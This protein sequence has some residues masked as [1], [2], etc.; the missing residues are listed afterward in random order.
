MIS[1]LD[2]KASLAAFLIALAA[3]GGAWGSQLFGGL[4]PCELCLEQ[5][6][7]YYLGVPVLAL[8]LLAWNRL[9]LPAWYLLMAVAIGCFALGAYMAGYHAGVEYGFWPGPTT[10]TGTGGPMSFDDLRK[11]DEARVVPC[12]KVQF[13]L[14]GVSLA[15]FNLLAQLAVVGLLLVAVW[16]QV[17]RQ[18]RAVAA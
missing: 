14:F 17:R 1:A 6:L 5:R 15:G 18:R 2:K 8:V 3:I 11:I 13:Q 7:A 4:V 10:C 16:D 9:P 12:D